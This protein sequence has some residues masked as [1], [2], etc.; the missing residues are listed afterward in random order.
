MLRER[1]D[2]LITWRE[3]MGFLNS[4]WDLVRKYEGVICDPFWSNRWGRCYQSRNAGRWWGLVG[5]EEEPRSHE[6]FWAS[7][8]AH[9]FESIYIPYIWP[10]LGTDVKERN[11]AALF[12]SFPL[13]KNLSERG[14]VVYSQTKV[15]ISRLFPRREVGSFFFL[16]SSW[17]RLPALVFSRIPRLR[18]VR[19][20]FS[21]FLHLSISER[22]S[23]I[24]SLKREVVWRGM[25]F[26]AQTS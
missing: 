7:K 17:S 19:P 10:C 20:R 1:N 11:W 23:I 9:F 24:H 3:E 25:C 12:T 22:C 13:V 5:G 16:W 15:H 8:P 14:R 2:R 6:S 26:L 4:G 21:Y 18:D